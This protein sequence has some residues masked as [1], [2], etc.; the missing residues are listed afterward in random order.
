[1]QQSTQ[2][3]DQY[4][5]WMWMC[6][7]WRF[8]MMQYLMQQLHFNLY[9]QLLLLMKI[10]YWCWYLQSQWIIV[11]MYLQFQLLYFMIQLMMIFWL[12][13]QLRLQLLQME[14]FIYQY[15]LMMIQLTLMVPPLMNQS[16]YLINQIT[17]H[18]KF[19]SYFAF[20]LYLNIYYITEPTQLMLKYRN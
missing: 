14:P 10:N 9:F 18:I 5:M 2:Q 13:F 1:M 19:L 20:R 11:L 3:K 4:W 12:C 8:M 17:L 6:W 7:R 15:Q 16:I